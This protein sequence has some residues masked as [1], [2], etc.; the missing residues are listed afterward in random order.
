MLVNGILTWFVGVPPVAAAHAAAEQSPAPLRGAPW[1][2][3]SPSPDTAH[4]LG[5]ERRSEGLVRPCANERLST[6]A[7]R[8]WRI[9]SREGI[10]STGALCSSLGADNQTTSRGDS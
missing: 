7:R 9:D 10:C 1:N 4:H 6:G 2:G 5:G 8:P 3:R